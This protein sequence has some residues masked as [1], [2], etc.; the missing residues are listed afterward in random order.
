[1]RVVAGLM[2]RCHIFLSNDSGLMHTAAACRMPCVSIFGP[3]NAVWMRP[4]NTPCV[5]VSRRLPC[6]PCF[7]YSCR[8]LLCPAGLNFACMRDLPVDMVYAAVQQLLAQ[9]DVPLTA[10]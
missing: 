10:T 4:W 1:M 7:Y 3:T 5:V 8:P 6:S 2:R 9:T